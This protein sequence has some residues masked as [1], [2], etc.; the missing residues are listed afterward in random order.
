VAIDTYPLPNSRLRAL[1]WGLAAPIEAATLAL[2]RLDERL[3]Q[4]D[5]DPVVHVLADGVRARAHVLE[6]Q[7]LVHLSGESVGLEELVLHEA[8]MD[9]RIPSTGTVRA[10]R[11][12]AER[13]SLARRRS[14]AVLSPDQV[15]RML[16]LEERG[17]GEG[18]S[19][20]EGPARAAVKAASD[21]AALPPAVGLAFQPWEMPRRSAADEDDGLWLEEE[22]EPEPEEPLLDDDADGRERRG[23]APS[24]PSHRSSDVGDSAGED[25]AA[26]DRLL[27][28]TSRTLA[29]EAG[30][31]DHPDVRLRDPAYGAEDRLAAWLDVLRQARRLP[32][33]VA[34]ALAL[35]AWLLL[36]P[37][38]RGGEGGWALVAT[39]LRERGLAK[40]HLPALGLA[41]RKGRF[42][43]G[44]HLPLERRVGGLL[45]AV[46]ES[47]ALASADLQRLTLARQVLLRRCQG[48]RGSSK[49][50]QFVDLFVQSPLVTVALAAEKLKV[51]PQAVEAMLKELGPSL[52]RELTGRK[53]YR[54]WGI[55]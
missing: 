2:V 54:A 15:R 10:A 18:A 26:I 22:G 21:A 23:G 36:E 46:G 47:A 55:V 51:T 30:N 45:A 50:P 20:G 28:R 29:I 4:C 12:L 9:I 41:Y 3:A 38:E 24:G 5:R 34:A 53:R 48:R 1:A 33:V 16:G 37:T 42:R 40:H 49:L 19:A 39:V 52:P 43:W 14:E 44:P 32:G 35:D 7:A 6:A 27:A 25:L 8:G 11:I 31:G 13:R 17:T